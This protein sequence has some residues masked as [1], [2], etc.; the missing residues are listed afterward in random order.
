MRCRLALLALCGL[1]SAPLLADDVTGEQIYTQQCARCHGAKGE[2]TEK[3]PAHL[4]GDRSLKE[5]TA[6]IDETMPEDDPKKC[7]GADAEKVAA[8]IHEAFY[9]IIAQERNRPARVELSHLTVRQ[10]ENAITDILQS[11]YGENMLDESRGLKAEYFKE[12]RRRKEARVIERNDNQVDFQFGEGTPDPLVD[13]KE[14]FSIEWE[15]SLLAPE[16]GIYDFIVETENGGR[17]FLNDEETPLIDASVRSG[18]QKEYTGTMRLLAGRTYRLR[19]EFFKAKE[20]TASIRLKWKLPHRPVEV[21]PQRYLSP[22]W[23]PRSFVLNTPFPPDDRSR[24]YDR[25]SAVSKE[26]YEATTAAALEAAATVVRDLDR[27]SKSKPEE[28]DRSQKVQEFCAKFAARA[29]RRP[30]DDA[31][32][33]FY[34]TRHFAEGVDIDTAT[35]RAITMILQSPRFLYREVN[36]GA[37]DD[38]DAASWLA[39]SLWDSIPDQQL[40]DAAGRGQLKTADQLTR[41]A[42]RMLQSPKART[43]VSDFIVRWLRLDHHQE[44]SKD[45]QAFPQFTPE[46]VSDLRTSLDLF[47]D[48]VIWK[49]SGDFRELL[50][51]DQL[52]LNGRLAA[53]Y[54]ADLAG[55]AAFQPVSLPAQSRAGILSHPL[56]LACLAY[57]RNSSPIHRGVWVSRGLLG[58]RLKAPP[59]AVAPLAPDLNPELT[60]RER[61]AIQTSPQACQTCHAMVNPL[62]FTLENFDAIGR[63]RTEEQGKPIDATGSYISRS[64]DEAKFATPKEF[65]SYLIASPECHEAFV[66]QLFHHLAKQPVRAFGN[67]FLAQRTE[68]FR[69]GEF[70]IRKLLVDLTVQSALELQK[71]PA[72]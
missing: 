6:L 46:I 70:N 62:G 3:V 35:R 36:Q 21:I 23:S 45:P 63:Y 16:T 65:A 28:G 7:V 20:K 38:F 18:D 72:P 30:I 29:V 53:V 25:G 17:F 19:L 13:N 8:Y 69:S 31:E 33:Q 39:F 60:T 34:V 5:L 15:G 14:E 10:H 24:G 64:G 50:S 1:I 9:S 11:F 37:F 44:L 43:K 47:V 61:V 52:Y 22:Q 26:W 66:E 12:R 59:V 67:E 27:L 54:G 58:R 4:I 71:Q 56:L 32:K 51:S 68:A 2:G 40:L 48:E 57:E 55:D 49:R 42:E 41:Q